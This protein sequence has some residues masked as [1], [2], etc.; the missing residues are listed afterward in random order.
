[1]RL[2]PESA[3]GRMILDSKP[4]ALVPPGL[5]ARRAGDSRS[6]RCTARS[7]P[8]RPPD[9]FGPEHHAHR[10]APLG[11][12]SARRVR[13]RPCRACTTQGRR[14]STSASTSSACRCSASATASRSRPTRSAARSSAPTTGEYGPAKVTVQRAEGHLRALPRGRVDRRVDV[15]RRPRRAPPRRVQKCSGTSPGRPSRP[16]PTRP[17]HL[18]RSVSPRGGPRR[19]GG[20]ARHR[21]PLRR[22]GPH[23]R[24]EPGAFVDEGPSRAS[25]RRFPRA[26]RSARSR[27]AST[28]R[29]L[30][31]RIIHRALGDKLQMH[32]R[33][34]RRAAEGERDQVGVP[35]RLPPRPAG[36][37]RARALLGAR[38]GERPE[39]KRKIIGRV[40][41]E[42]FEERR[43][44]S[45]G[46]THLVQGRSTRRDR[47][48]CPFR[49]RAP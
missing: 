22:R 49:D 9:D 33:R 20:D 11:D 37:R 36:G 34:Q 41:I 17:A 13:R 19:A 5:I 15:A 40:F 45:T 8:A 10:P 24:L 14:A 25:G 21:L 47:V 32:L 31:V 18:R 29:W 46:V 12:S 16:W 23:A 48:A 39:A 27:A 30:P 43:R 4:G 6:S 35:R 26:T 38:R 1:M 2:L 28:A 7:S 3:T 44:S 42:V